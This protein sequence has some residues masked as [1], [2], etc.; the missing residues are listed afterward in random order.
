MLTTA[1]MVIDPRHDHSMRIPRPDVSAKIGSPNACNNCHSKET[2]QWA[3]HAIRAWTGEAPAS[4]Q[5]FAEA[6]RA[7]SAGAPG[8]RGALLD[9]INDKA[10]PAI[11]RASAI[12]RLGH[13]LTPTTLDPAT[14]SLSDPDSVVRLAA[15]EALANVDPTIRRRYLPRLLHDPVRAV[16]IA[17]A[18]ALVTPRNNCR[19]ANAPN[20]TKRSRST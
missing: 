8:A 18:R 12:D 6:L 16:R 3:A 20:S 7:G 10:Q 15:V 2:A 19:K 5:N 1:Y 17:A 11:V 4:Y 9:V 13:W 14:R